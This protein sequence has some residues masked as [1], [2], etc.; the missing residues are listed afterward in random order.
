MKKILVLTL[1][2]LLGPVI[3]AAVASKDSPQTP[4]PKAD[5][6]KWAI[7]DLNRPLPPVVDSGA[8][9]PP[10]VAP[11]DAVVLFDGK[12]LIQWEDGKGGA[13]KWKV[14]GGFMEVVA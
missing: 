1:V 14:E 10:V 4:A 12:D 8:A 9:G 7:H 6:E 11:S 5:L 3:M 2:L 13:A